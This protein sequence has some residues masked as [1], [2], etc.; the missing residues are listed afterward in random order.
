MLEAEEAG[1][2]D[3]VAAEA[4]DN[5][6]GVGV[7]GVGVTGVGG[8]GVT[9]LTDPSDPNPEPDFVNEALGGRGLGMR[10]GMR[11]DGIGEGPVDMANG[12]RLM[13]VGRGESGKA[14]AALGT[15]PAPGISGMDTAGILGGANG[16]GT[17]GMGNAPGPVAGGIAGTATGTDL[18]RCI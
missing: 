6:E 5:P 4:S 11:D 2:D 16:A 18:G 10:L 12:G 3:V 8:V 14:V 15:A 17:G 7:M 9:G 13:A 1:V